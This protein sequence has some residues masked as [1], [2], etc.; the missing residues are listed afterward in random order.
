MFTSCCPAW[1]KFLQ[2]WRP[3]LEKNLTTVLSP[4]LHAGLAYKTW[5]AEINGIDPSK[6][7]VIS[8]MPCTTKKE[9]NC[10][11]NGLKAVDAVLTV[12]E[13]AQLMRE[14]NLNLA[15]AEESE[16]D[17]LADYTG[18][19]IIFG[20]SGGVTE[21]AL[22]VLKKKVD[23]EELRPLSLE[24][25]TEAGAYFRATSLVVGGHQLTAAIIA[26]PRNF[27]IFLQ[28]DLYK[29]YSY[30]E[31]MNCPG[32][33]I[34]G[35]GQPLLP[36]N[37]KVAADLLGKRRELLQTLDTG[38]QRRNALDNQLVNQYLEWVTTKNLSMQ[39]LERVKF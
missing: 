17:V 38:R 24:P 7:V 18:G 33:C 25:V 3:D 28:K 23:G 21:S 16:G 8:L 11:F 2:Q 37:P 31:V 5:W 13:L 20:K 22:R 4:H 30:V 34:G 10:E 12:R 35:G 6:L 27:K 26:E 39:L 14:K 32:G 36:A 19:A 29:K 1:V 9:E 15:D